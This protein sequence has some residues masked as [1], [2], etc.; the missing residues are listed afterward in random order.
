MRREGEC[1]AF[2]GEIK[3]PEQW[4]IKMFISTWHNNSDRLLLALPVDVCT[5]RR[6]LHSCC[7]LVGTCTYAADTSRYVMSVTSV[8]CNRA[9]ERYWSAASSATRSAAVAMY[10]ECMSGGMV[11]RR[12]AGCVARI[13][14]APCCCPWRSQRSHAS[15]RLF[16]CVCKQ[17]GRRL[18]C[19]RCIQQVGQTSYGY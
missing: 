2:T 14:C 5:G 18:Q 1:L 16:L 9:T 15:A 3:G 4:W 17:C 19:A 7:Q 10:V 13:D 6:L 11:E 12:R 8:I